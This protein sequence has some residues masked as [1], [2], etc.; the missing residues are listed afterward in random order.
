MRYG[1]DEEANMDRDTESEKLLLAEVRFLHLIARSLCRN[2]CD[3]DDLV[4]ETLLRAWANLDIFERGTSLEKW[5]YVIMRN[6]YRGEYWK[7]RREVADADGQLAERR[8]TLPDQL[9]ALALAETTRAMRELPSD[10]LEALLRVSAGA[11]YEEVA[12]DCHCAVGTVKS[13][14][15]RSRNFL[16]NRLKVEPNRDLVPDPVFLAPLGA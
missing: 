13:R 2:E 7:R 1:T 15:Q 9:D 3:V 4:Q 10:Q 11:S 6:T 16:R 14:V 8:G 12:A 5:L